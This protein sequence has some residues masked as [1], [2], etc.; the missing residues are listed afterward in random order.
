MEFNVSLNGVNGRNR[1][2]PSRQLTHAQS[3]AMG[4]KTHVLITALTQSSYSRAGGSNS[5]V[6]RPFPKMGGPGVLPRKILEKYC[7]LV[8]SGTI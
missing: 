5:A 8:H 3:D 4:N 7:L 2:R 6:V 1:A